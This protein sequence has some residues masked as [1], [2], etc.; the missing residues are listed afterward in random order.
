V[1]A[2]ILALLLAACGAEVV[3]PS[4][5]ASLPAPTEVPTPATTATPSPAPS[6]TPTASAKP[7]PAPSASPGSSPNP[8]AVCPG[9]VQVVKSLGTPVKDASS[10]WSGYTVSS[11][12]TP[13]TCVEA[14]WTQP[15]VDCRGSSLKAVAYWVGIGGVG[16][17][18]LVQTGTETQ[19][20]HGSAV[21][22]AWQQSLPQERYAVPLDLTVAAGD[23]VHAQV[24][25]VGRT[26]YTLTVEDLT[27]GASVTA[28]VVNRTVHPT[29]AEWIVE[30]PTVGCPAR[31]AIATLPDFGTVAFTRVAV[32]VNGANAPLDAAGVAHTRTTLTTSSGLTRAGVTATGKDGRSFSVT[33]RRP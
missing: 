32:T 10:D 28:T 12:S 11:S 19:C 31:C 13:F 26:S 25:A 15:S 9:K 21:I 5:A 33:W 27:T 24:L 29:T 17:V 20:L 22:G 3:S 23:Q 8:V 4:A 6:P 1:L 16:Q 14:T 30:A 18:G 7:T 2:L